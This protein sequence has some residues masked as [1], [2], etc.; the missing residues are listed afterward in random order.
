MNIKDTKNFTKGTKATQR[1]PRQ[2]V[3]NG[4]LSNVIVIFCAAN[5]GNKPPPQYFAAM[6][7]ILP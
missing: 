6:P 4:V 5:A 7:E 2:D 3:D 1:T